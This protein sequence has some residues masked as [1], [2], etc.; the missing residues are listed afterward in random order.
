M[1]NNED[2]ALVACAQPHH[3][4][5]GC[6]RLTHVKGSNCLCY[7]MVGHML[8]DFGLQSLCK[9]RMLRHGSSNCFLGSLKGRHIGPGFDDCASTGRF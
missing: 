9:F 2:C 6:V 5:L 1:T 7:R 4:L 3:A 8:N